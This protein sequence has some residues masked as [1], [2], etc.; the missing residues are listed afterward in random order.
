MKRKRWLFGFRSGTP[1]KKIVAVI[2]YFLGVVVLFFGL[3]T[4]PFIEAGV[5]DTNIYRITVVILFFWIESPAIFLSDTPIRE[6]LPF[7]RKRKASQSLVGF[8]CM[9]ILFV[10]MFATI[11][12]YH[13]DEYRNRLNK[14]MGIST[15]EV[16]EVEGGEG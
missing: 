10:Y 14:Y 16:V 9:S 3:F 7:F 12:S 11:D 4:P 8:M 15:L 2:Y 6:K 13:T 5:H 1:W